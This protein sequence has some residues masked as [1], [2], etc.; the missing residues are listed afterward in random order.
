MMRFP[1]LRSGDIEWHEFE[2]LQ[3]LVELWRPGG[4]YASGDLVRPSASSGFFYECTTAGM[5][6]AREPNFARTSG[7]TTSDGSVVWTARTP[8]AASEPTISSCVYAFAPSGE[9]T[10]DDVAIDNNRMVT[11]IRIDATGAKL[12]DYEI[13]ATMT[14]SAGEDFIRKAMLR[15]IA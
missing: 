1:D 15:I 9:L 10:Q 6:A 5:S 2:W 12:G 7:V 14:D 13:T 8:A 4:V 3:T 11:K